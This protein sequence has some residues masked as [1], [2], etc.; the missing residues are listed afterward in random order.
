MTNAGRTFPIRRGDA[1][2]LIGDM[3]IDQARAVATLL[4]RLSDKTAPNAVYS[5]PQAGHFQEHVKEGNQGADV[6]CHVLISLAPEIGLPNTYTCAVERMPGLPS[7]L[8][9]R[10][11]SKLL[12]YEY[13]ANP[14][15][16]QY[17]HP[18]GGQDRHGN[19]R[20][21]RCCP[22]IELRGRPSDTL[23]NDINNG[24]LSGVSLIRTEAAT[25]IGGAAYLTK[26]ASELK[27]AIDHNNLP[28]NLWQGLQQAFQQ[29]AGAYPVAKVAYRT[30]GSS[31]SVTV[32]IDS[33]NGTPL[34]D[35]YVK[36]FE[37]RN[38]FPFLA[39]STRSI[40]PHLRDLAIP[41]L[42][43]ERHV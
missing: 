5:D 4:V 20:L 16:Y 8:V 24:H 22:H 42:V 3:E 30:P 40:V 38:I 31:R 12:N 28:A 41:Q 32:E 11:L 6:G 18:G 19:P 7:D 33:H 13:R 29:N 9:R 14:A 1:T 23:I 35:I 26:K 10:L 17:P 34:N 2:L 21:D 36:S 27:L 43:A 37:L 39:Q 25:P 15:F